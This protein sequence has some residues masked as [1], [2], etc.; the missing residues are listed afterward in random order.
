LPLKG[1]G[2]KTICTRG[3]DHLYLWPYL[4]RTYRR[5]TISYSPLTTFAIASE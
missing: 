2:N 3:N 4:L 1:P 5:P